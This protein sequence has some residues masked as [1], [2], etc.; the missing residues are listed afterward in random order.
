MLSDL[1]I[2]QKPRPRAEGGGL[3][4][5]ASRAEIAQFFRAFNTAADR[6]GADVLHGPGIRVE[7]PPMQDPV[8]QLTITVTE[9]ELFHI[10][11]FGTQ[12]E[13]RGRLLRAT[14]ERGWRFFDPV[15]SEYVPP[16]H[17]GADDDDDD[18]DRGYGSDDDDE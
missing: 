3:A 7:M 5:L 10:L 2:L 6:A 4:P 16:Y 17:D 9:D 11:F 1:Y 15:R 12:N 18:D 13:P 14:L 8:L